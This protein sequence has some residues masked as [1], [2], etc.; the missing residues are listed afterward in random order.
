MQTQRTQGRIRRAWD[1]TRSLLQSHAKQQRKQEP[2]P[3][4][5]R[6]RETHEKVLARKLLEAGDGYE[7]KPLKK[8]VRIAHGVRISFRDAAELQD[9]KS[10]EVAFRKRAEIT[11]KYRMGQVPLGAAQQAMEEWSRNFWGIKSSQ[12]KIRVAK[13]IDAK[14]AEF[15]DMQLL[16]ENISKIDLPFLQ[17]LLLPPKQEEEKSGHGPA[18]AE[19]KPA[20]NRVILLPAGEEEPKASSGNGRRPI[21]SHPA[22]VLIFEHEKKISG[23]MDPLLQYT[24]PA[25]SREIDVLW[26]D[27][28]TA[29]E[30]AKSRKSSAEDRKMALVVMQIVFEEMMRL[31]EKAV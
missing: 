5:G 26:A 7:L 3:H 31:E 16:T 6:P 18:K 2:K 28:R 9:D 25:L 19:E 23:K 11:W 22:D 4:H 21:S 20:E 14:R 27:Y 12:Q 24:N 29:Y 15:V 13:G 17:V 8:S 10:M 1:R 30:T